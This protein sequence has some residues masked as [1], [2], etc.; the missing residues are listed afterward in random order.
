MI[1]SSLSHSSSPRPARPA[2][3]PETP[4]P[5]AQRAASPSASQLPLVR[6][7]LLASWFAEAPNPRRA[8]PGLD[9]QAYNDFCEREL[10]ACTVA[11]RALE[12]T[13]D[14]RSL[15]CHRGVVH[16]MHELRKCGAGDP[17]QRRTSAS[18][19]VPERLLRLSEHDLELKQP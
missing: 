15:G 2:P 16:R 13:H 12:G 1:S 6:E 10:R 11:R 9:S 14:V 8:Y 7:T 19:H 3:N 5:E 17:M 4:Q 18:L